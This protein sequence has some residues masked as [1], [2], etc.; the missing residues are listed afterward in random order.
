MKEHITLLA[1]RLKPERYE[2][3]GA[4]GSKGA[5]VTASAAIM[6]AIKA[7]AIENFMIESVEK[8]VFSLGRRGTGSKSSEN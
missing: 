4:L 2:T 5:A 1:P 7:L 8:G 6:A 3:F